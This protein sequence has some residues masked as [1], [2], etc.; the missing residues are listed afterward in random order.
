MSVYFWFIAT[1]WQ[2]ASLQ[3][4]NLYQLIK[5]RQ[6]PFSEEEIRSFMKQVLRG[7]S[8]MHKKGFFHRDLKPGK[9]YCTTAYFCRHHL[10]IFFPMYLMCQISHVLIVHI[11]SVKKICWWQMMFLKLLILDWLE[12]YHQCL[13]ILNMFPHGGKSCSFCPIFLFFFLPGYE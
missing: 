8:H 13:L 4:C 2:W 11:S 3:D 10:Y 5:D 9:T 12:K 6:K 7:L 1:F